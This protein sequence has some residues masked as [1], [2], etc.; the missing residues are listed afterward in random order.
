[1][2]ILINN[3]LALLL[4]LRIVCALVVFI[5]LTVIIR[6]WLLKKIE[7]LV[8]ARVKKALRVKDLAMRMKSGLDAIPIIQEDLQNPI[9]TLKYRSATILFADIQ[10]FTKIVK[11]L[12]P[13]KLIDEL[14]SLFIHFDD[15]VDRYGVEKIKTIGDAY[16]AASGI[17]KENSSHA[18]EMGLVAMEIQ[19][20]M[21]HL[22]QKK[23]SQNED[24]WELRIGID[25]GPVIAGRLG[26]KKSNFDIWGDTVNTAS[27][28]EA[29]SLPNEINI[30]DS[31][32]QMVKE[33]FIC[34]YRG[35]MPVK[36]KGTID[37][38]FIKGI[39]SELSVDNLGLMP[40]KMF[41]THLQMVRFI[42]MESTVL[43]RMDK[44][45]PANMFYH[46]SRHTMDVI[47]QVEV[48]ARNEKVGDEDL[49]LLKTAAL[50]HDTGFLIEYE[51]HEYNSTIIAA[52]ILSSFG[53]SQVQID[54]VNQLLLATH[55]DHKPTNLLEM[56]IKDADLDHLGRDDF[57]NL[58][59]RLFKEVQFFNG[60]IEKEMWQK[61]QL[62]FLNKHE[63][64]TKT[65]KLLREK[66][67]L[68]H[69]QKLKDIIAHKK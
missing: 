64:Y 20:H 23:K 42:K 57:F 7:V 10:G 8:Q 49:L 17:P 53:Y 44:E 34:E 52:N 32:Y 38:Y 59:N 4:P 26:H 36:Y 13:E 65:G 37:M 31:T 66:Y 47:T 16:M 45:L 63:F 19:Q 6:R 58:S 55:P 39:R 50:L 60:D 51:N 11:N 22:R 25:S 29:S 68:Q 28:M 1:M 30:T 5:L 3:L 21:H 46:N 62:K 2:H 48:I 56:I 9:R 33:F 54:Q 41:Q 24:F 35:Q 12:E 27:R 69:I 14:D 40:N 67:K 15:I 43:D 61:Q 18:I